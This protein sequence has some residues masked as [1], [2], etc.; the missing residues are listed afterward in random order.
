MTTE[1]AVPR[2]I[3]GSIVVGG[4]SHDFDFVRAEL[5]RLFAEQ[6]HVR[7]SVSST[8]EELRFMGASRFLVTYT[9]DVRPSAAAADALEAFVRAG[10][11]WFALHATN[12]F[13]EWTSEGVASAHTEGPFFGTLGSAFIAHPPMGTYRVDV[14]APEDPLVA[15]I[16]PFEVEDELYLSEFFGPHEVLLAT[17]FVGK[18]PGFVVDDWPGPSLRPVMY[19]KRVGNGEVLYLTLGHA[20]GHWDA[21]HRTPYYPRVERGSW[22]SPAFRELVSR[23]IRWA[24]GVAPFSY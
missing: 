6:D 24:A 2:R 13:L 23:G 1:K 3:D 17:E 11:R 9:C 8:F 22:S 21:P 19:R 7:L 12:S 4:A 20:R 14:V 10:G 16:E 5:L 18:A 15:G